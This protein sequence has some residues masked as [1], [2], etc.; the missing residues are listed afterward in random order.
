MREINSITDLL[1]ELKYYGNK[2]IEATESFDYYH[3]GKW[4]VSLN[5]ATFYVKLYGIISNDSSK[6]N[7]KHL[8]ELN[9]PI[10][11]MY[12]HMKTGI[13]HNFID[14]VT[15]WIN[16]KHDMVGSSKTSAYN[17]QCGMALF[18][19]ES[20]RCFQ[21]HI[22]NMMSLDLFHH[23]YLDHE[24]L[25]NSHPMAHPETWKIKKIGLNMLMTSNEEIKEHYENKQTFINIKNRISCIGKTWLSHSETDY[26]Q[27][28]WSKPKMLM[29]KYLKCVILILWCQC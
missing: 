21:N 17:A 13:G 25:F 24:F 8:D 7:T 16:G 6:E 20:I 14:E 22:T 3:F 18:L 26:F 29:K 15:Y 28:S 4:V 12:K 9:R 5:K 23:G 2:E 1:K 27:G 19:S 10:P 11:V